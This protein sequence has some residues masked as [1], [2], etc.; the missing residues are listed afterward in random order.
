MQ[1]HTLRRK[2]PPVASI[3]LLWTTL[4]AGGVEAK[5]TQPLR[6]EGVVHSWALAPGDGSQ[7]GDRAGMAYELAPGTATH[8]AVTLFNFSNVKL[9]FDVYATDAFNNADGAFDLLAGDDNPSDV[10][11]WITLPQRQVA[12]EAGKQVTLPITL[13]VPAD[14]QPGDHAGAIL[15]SSAAMGTAPNGKVVNLDRRTGTRVYVR[16][17][18]RL[19]P[20]VS[21]ARVEASYTP[22][23]NPFG[24]RARVTYRIEN[25]G[26]VRVGGTHRVSVSGPLGVLRRSST[27]EE[28][29]ELLPGESFTVTRT[30]RG[31]PATVVAVANVEFRAKPDGSAL[32]GL[33]ASRRRS[34]AFAVPLTIIALLLGAGLVH[35]ARRSYLRHRGP[36]AVLAP[37]VG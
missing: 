20:R 6:V 3:L 11:T 18:G 4:F 29:A 36:A 19:T 31:V 30:L 2:T 35:Y 32:D 12:V 15:A 33:D 34:F 37:E 17:A 21:V 1:T 8:D 27:A 13:R 14:A 5:E 10:G 7:Q 26:N 25:R 16:V 24:G 9:V 28:L 23:L 22:A